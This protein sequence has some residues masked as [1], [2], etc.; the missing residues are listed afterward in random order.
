MKNV[1]IIDDSVEIQM[2]LKM[3]LES[4]G[5]HVDCSLNGEEALN[6]LSLQQELPALILLDIQMPVM[7]GLS[8]LNRLKAASRIRGIPVVLMSGEEDILRTGTL[9]NVRSVLKK[10]LDIMSV[11]RTVEGIIKLNGPSVEQTL[12]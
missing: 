11:L 12:H 3:L 1:L 4:K 8:F 5:Y 9:A 7:D 2:L 6:L 10:P